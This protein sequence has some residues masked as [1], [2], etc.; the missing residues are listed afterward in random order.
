MALSIRDMR[1]NSHKFV[2]TDAC[3]QVMVYF[4]GLKDEDRIMNP[5]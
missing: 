5:I 3:Q 1:T 2:Q 4:K